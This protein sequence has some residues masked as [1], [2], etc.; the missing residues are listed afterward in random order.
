MIDN[1]AEAAP[2]T[3]PP[4][5]EDT[6]ALRDTDARELGEAG[7]EEVVEKGANRCLDL[8]CHHAH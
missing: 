1:L 3:A 6:G 7:E 4:V 5:R 8:P 2:K